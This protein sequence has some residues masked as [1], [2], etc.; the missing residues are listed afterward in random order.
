M[1][2]ELSWAK[3]LERVG[4][5]KEFTFDADSS[6]RILETEDPDD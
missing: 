6:P 5:G 1:A 2:E 4:K 3:Y